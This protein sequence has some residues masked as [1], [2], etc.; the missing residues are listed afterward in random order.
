MREG[1]AV[2][3]VLHDLAAAAAYADR[4]V[5]L[6]HGSCI[7]HGTPAEVFDSETL[8]S[9]YA[10]PIRVLQQPAADGGTELH[11]VPERYAD[12]SAATTAPAD[13]GGSTLED[14]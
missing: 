7:A 8:S 2:C 10:H 14:Q 12:T 9:V 4:V 1:A 5:L 3:I 11:I 13:L 6:S